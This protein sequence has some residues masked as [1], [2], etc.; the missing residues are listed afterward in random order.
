MLAAPE[1]TGL[2][3]ISR[4]GIETKAAGGDAGFINDSIL[5]KSRYREALGAV[6]PLG[7]FGTPGNG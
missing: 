2:R 7:V 3:C 6:H 1:E 4:K 5:Y